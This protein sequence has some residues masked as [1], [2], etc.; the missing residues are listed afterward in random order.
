MRD[1]PLIAVG[2]L[3][4]NVRWHEFLNSVSLA[5]SLAS[6]LCFV[7]LFHWLEFCVLCVVCCVLCWGEV[8]P[9]YLSGCMLLCYVFFLFCVVRVC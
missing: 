4:C 2:R 1:V 9:M 5:Y 7:C 3:L 8:A 6:I